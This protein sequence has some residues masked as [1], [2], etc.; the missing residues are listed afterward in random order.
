MTKR[1]FL[2]IMLMTLLF[3]D[4]NCSYEDG[5][6]ESDDEGWNS[7]YHDMEAMLEKPGSVFGGSVLGGMHDEAENIHEPAEFPEEVEEM[8]K[9]LDSIDEDQAKL[10]EIER[11][12][13]HYY[14]TYYDDL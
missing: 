10:D 13:K 5:D 8:L 14:K 3:I 11:E 2:L 4:Y 7:N 9:L 12:E 6:H 1:I